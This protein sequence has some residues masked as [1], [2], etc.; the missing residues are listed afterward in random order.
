MSA[1]Y[2]TAQKEKRAKIK[3][4]KKAATK[5][6]YAAWRDAGTNSKRSAIRK[7]KARRGL[8]MDRQR[9]RSKV[10]VEIPKTG[11]TLTQKQFRNTMTLRN[12]LRTVAR[13]RKW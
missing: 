4:A 2:K 8:R 9:R 5:A 13:E 12:F 11:V 1:K 7:S 3:R 10:L 6:Q